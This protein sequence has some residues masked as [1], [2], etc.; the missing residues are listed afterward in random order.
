MAA[1]RNTAYCI[2]KAGYGG[3]MSKGEARVVKEYG[4]SLQL[5]AS[6]PSAGFFCVGM[7]VPP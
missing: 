1:H 2:Y 6:H 4:E 7:G 5:D 3:G